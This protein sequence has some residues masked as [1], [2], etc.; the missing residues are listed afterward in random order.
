MKP[1]LES[2]TTLISEG[3]QWHINN[4]VS[5][6]ENVFRA[7]SKNFFELYNE[8][9]TLWESNKLIVND[10]EL[11]WHRDKK[12]ELLKFYRVMVGYYN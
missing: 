4:N 9:R 7:G 6:S 8:A 10:M 1:L 2:K 5:L 11:V 12:T 3:L